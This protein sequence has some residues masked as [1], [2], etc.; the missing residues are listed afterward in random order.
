MSDTKELLV[1]ELRICAQ[2]I[3]ESMELEAKAFLLSIA[4]ELITA[5][6]Y[7]DEDDELKFAEVVLRLSYALV[8]TKLEDNEESYLM[9]DIKE[10]IDKIAKH[11]IQIS[12][13]IENGQN[14]HG[15]L[16]NIITTIYPLT[17]IGIYNNIKIQ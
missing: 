16:Q 3:L 13:N 12:T 15:V 6:I 7:F 4:G 14:Y 5:Y 10:I 9:P 1:R 2:K 17:D 8:D 11:I